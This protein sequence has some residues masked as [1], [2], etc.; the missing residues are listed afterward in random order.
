MQNSCLIKQI[1]K[2]SFLSLFI[3]GLTACGFQL[4]GSYAVP[5]NMQFICFDDGGKYDLG[6]ALKQR[7]VHSKVSLINDTASCVSLTIIDTKIE[8]PVLSLFPNAQVAEYELNYQVFYSIQYPHEESART[9]TAQV[10][11]DYQDDPEAV[12]A[13]SKEMKLML[14][15]LRRHA[16]EQ[17]VL[18]L[19]SLDK[20]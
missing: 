14:A 5:P 13:K 8:R 4:R 10:A 12:L 3:F 18:Q 16:A 7:L 17:I 1:S 15:E 20:R 9:F 19:A 2:L 6:K 11:R